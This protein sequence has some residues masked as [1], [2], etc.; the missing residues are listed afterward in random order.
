MLGEL[1][2]PMGCESLLWVHITHAASWSK[3]C[4]AVCR[5][6]GAEMAPGMGCTH[7]GS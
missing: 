3:I 5:V 1:L 2:H 6:F 7:P 4:D